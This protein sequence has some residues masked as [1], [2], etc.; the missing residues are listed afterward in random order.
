MCVKPHRGSSL[1]LCSLALL[2]VSISVAALHGDPPVAAASG[3]DSAGKPD[4]YRRREIDLA[5]QFAGFDAGFVLL[6]ESQHEQLVFNELRCAEQRSPCSTF[7]VPHTLIALSTGALNG[8]DDVIEWDHVTR[9]RAELNHDHD[10]RSAIRDSVLWY[11]QGVAKRVGMEKERE[12]LAK[13][14]YGNQATGDD[15]TNFWIDGSLRISAF[16]QLDFVR[17][18]AREELPADKR[19]QQLVKELILVDRG[20]NWALFGKTGTGGEAKKASLGWF[21]GWLRYQQRNVYFAANIRA[22]DGATGPRCRGIVR[23][24]LAE[25]FAAEIAEK[26]RGR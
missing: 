10:L 26:S 6:D 14:G 18:L 22:D 21:V 20:D 7:K 17:R 13:L 2:F 15:L 24:I 16:E 12:W 11:F 5:R 9:D 19:T 25:R 8:A 4:E 1:F 23:T 3:G